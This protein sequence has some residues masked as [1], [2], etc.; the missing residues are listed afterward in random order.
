MTAK[1]NNK[2]LESIK[3]EFDFESANLKLERMNSKDLKF[4]YEKSTFYDSITYED[5]NDQMN[6]DKQKELDSATFGSEEIN[7]SN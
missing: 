3:E 4:A 1:P 2:M 6:Y 7:F 5:K